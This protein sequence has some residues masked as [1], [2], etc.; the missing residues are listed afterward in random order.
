[1]NS[2]RNYY[3]TLF[4]DGLVPFIPPRTCISTSASGVVSAGLDV[5]IQSVACPISVVETHDDRSRCLYFATI[6]GKDVTGTLLADDTVEVVV[7][8]TARYNGI[9][10]KLL[11]HGLAPA[12]HVFCPI[13]VG[14]NMVVMGCVPGVFAWELHKESCRSRS[15]LPPF[16]V[17]RRKR[18]TCCTHRTLSLVMCE[19][20]IRRLCHVG[21]L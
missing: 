5:P 11:E 17:T 8:F 20:R 16:T 10:H 6:D 13:F 19:C 9:A 2:L 21:R 18:S 7:R 15:F 4:E 1:M 3:R 14:L 12:V